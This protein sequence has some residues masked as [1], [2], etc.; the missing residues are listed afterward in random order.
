MFFHNVKEDLPAGSKRIP[1][2]L[3][4]RE[5]DPSYSRRQYNFIEVKPSFAGSKC[6][7]RELCLEYL[8][9]NPANQQYHPKHSYD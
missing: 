6:F 3:G 9:L 4:S 1:R 2:Y 7:H 8:A 5:G